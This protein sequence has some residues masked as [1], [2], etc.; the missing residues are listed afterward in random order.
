[1]DIDYKQ[2]YGDIIASGNSE[3]LIRFLKPLGEKEKKALV[4]LIKKD[5]KRLYT[6]QKLDDR[7]HWG[8]LGTKEQQDML[9]V[10]TLACYGRSDCKSIKHD[11]LFPN[12]VI[13]RV[14]DWYCPEW[15]S[16]YVDSLKDREHIPICYEQLA[17]WLAKGYIS[18]LA[19][20]LIAIQITSAFNHIE[21]HAFTL[22]EHIWQI[23]H[24]PCGVSWDNYWYPSESR[25][26]DAGDKK[27][28]YV[29]Q[30]YTQNKRLDRM[31]VLRE[32]LLAVNRNLDKNQTCWYAELFSELAPTAE[33]CSQLQEEL[34]S[35]FCCPQ[36]KPINTALGAIKTLCE[37]ADF[38]SD[39]FIAQ[40]PL[41]LSSATKG[42]VNS[43]LVIADKLAKRLPERRR[44][45]C[46]YV[47]GAFLNKEADLQNRAAKLLVKYGEPLD[48]E[49]SAQLLGYADNILLDARRLLADF[50]DAQT[51]TLAVAE[52]VSDKEEVRPLIREDNRIPEIASW[53][54]FVFLAG[55]AFLNTES[56]H[57]DQFPA[58]L[59][60]FAGEINERTVSQLEPAFA[61]ACKV[62]DVWSSSIGYF[63]RILAVFFLEYG[64]KLAARFPEQ[65]EN[66][67]TPKSNCE[68]TLNRKNSRMVK[69]F[70]YAD[71]LTWVLEQLEGGSTL[72]LL[73]TPT[74]LPCF[75]EPQVLVARL[76]QYQ[77]ANAQPCS[78][79]LQL[80]IQ[81]CALGG[82]SV[83]L[84]ALSGE[85]LFLMRYLLLGDLDALAQ[86][87]HDD[88][89]LAAIITRSG[90]M[91]D[92]ASFDA[93]YETLDKKQLPGEMLSSL[94]PWQIRYKKERY[95]Y[96]NQEI[97]TKTLHIDLTRHWRVD[98]SLFYEYAFMKSSSH[99]YDWG[100]DKRRSVFSFPWTPDAVLAR[101]VEG[102]FERADIKEVKPI[103]EMLQAVYDLPLSLTPMG[104]LLIAFSM[105]HSDKT[106]R[107]LAA[108]IWA[109][110]LP[111]GSS[112]IGNTIGLLEREEWAPLKRFT[113]LAMQ[114]MMG[115]S[116]R[117]N[118]ALEQMV[119]EIDAHLTD[120]NITNYKKLTA[121]HQELRE[122]NR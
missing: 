106:V 33:E 24:Y 39:T 70:P 14:L 31:R 117:H 19:P 74:H 12:R 20:E 15:F 5:V 21:K 87:Q 56:Y 6:F 38:R 71:M 2:K 75:I 1:M 109:D 50:L 25:P 67:P 94:F 49:L 73:S 90:H 68:N 92:A 118:L 104:Q 100:T 17:D 91:P 63:D 66:L 111:S 10:A 8:Y 53:D 42:I 45:I 113:D 28:I 34:F 13:D 16:D 55:R 36:S 35:T 46:L 108:A 3:Q 99:S 52:S 120:S 77:K 44:E 97:I 80:A 84:D 51:A 88:W 40:L 122:M 54:D 64:R 119:A 83:A 96:G 69:Y 110:K 89:K 81:R 43:A 29:F 86:I 32:C 41:L 62:I 4:P 101:F 95:S 30:K 105:L 107:A 103:T 85:Y 47:A 78:M 114:S 93:G 23:F 27:W 7:G 60:R 9:A 121:L 57:F 58:A 22:D 59:L 48:A 61:L 72:P 11:L 76:S 116:R 65:M 37:R 26:A 98:A 82:E 79:D 115:L 112:L 102:H 18:S